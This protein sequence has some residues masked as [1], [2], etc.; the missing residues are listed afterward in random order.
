MLT[1]ITDRQVTYKQGAT[2][3]VVRNLGDKL[4]ESVSVLDFGADSTGSVNC[5]TAMT[6]AWNEC[7]ATGKD[8]YIPAGLYV[9]T[10]E[11]SFPFG[12]VNGLPPADLLDCK[13]ITIYG[14]GPNTVLKT[15]TIG[16]GDVLQINGSKNL[17]F[18]NLKIESVISGSASGSNGV[19]V[20]GGF[21]NLTFDNIWCENLA[22]VDKGTYIDGGSALSIQTPDVSTVTECG[23]IKA[24]N[25]FAKGCAIGFGYS[26]DLVKSSTNAT[27]I[28]VDIVA[29]DCREA[30]V[31]SAG[32]ATAAISA[33]W[34][35][36]LSV[37]AQAIN[38][39]QDVVAARAH[40]VDI[41][42]QVITTKTSAARIL[43]YKGTK[44][45][46]TDT[47]DDVS[48]LQ[49]MYAHLSHIKLTGNKGECGS[50]AQ[51]GGAGAGSSGLTGA[52]Y[53]S[54]ISV[55]L[56]GTSVYGDFGEINSG[57]DITSTCVLIAGPNTAAPSNGHYLPSRNNLIVYGQTNVL[58]E[59]WV[60]GA[61]KFSTAD[62]LVTYGGEVDF[63]DEGIIVKQKN[64]SSTDTRVLKVMSNAGTLVAGFRN[65]GG[66]V[67]QGRSTAA[68]VATVKQVMPVYDNANTLIGYIP[69]YTSFA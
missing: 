57:G 46:A 35:M 42:C 59:L 34:T 8:L 44:W 47:T 11:N 41:D 25:I 54:T 19:S 38:C 39:M 49:C 63:D 58:D 28:S 50:K 6:N 2:G 9:I 66:L 60:R 24:T 40:G 14:D 18:K 56:A 52:T 33:S 55:D 53:K 32:E 13:N 48:G 17:H 10:S 69:I 21:D 12:R 4:R 64:A 31:V 51:V 30:V 22:F 26:L 61:V 29:E 7:L 36:G 37:K 5:F 68:S 45:F 67:S 15:S 1:K 62:G 65:D 27:S 3:S 43:S 23:T 16:G 20:T